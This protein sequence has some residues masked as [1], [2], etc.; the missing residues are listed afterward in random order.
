MSVTSDDLDVI[1]SRGCPCREAGE[2]EEGQEKGHPDV[3]S[4]SNSQNPQGKTEP[5]K[6]RKEAGLIH[7]VITVIP[8]GRE[9]TSIGKSDSSA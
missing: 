6:A 4:Y 9:H 8:Q 3:T 7:V 1:G 5:N 2:S